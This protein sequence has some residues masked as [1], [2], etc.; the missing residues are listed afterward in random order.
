MSGLAIHLRILHYSDRLSLESEGGLTFIAQRFRFADGLYLAMV[1]RN[2]PSFFE[3]DRANGYFFDTLH[4]CLLCS[5]DP[6]SSQSLL[7]E[8]SV[9]MV[10]YGGDS[11]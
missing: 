8:Y 9:T 4:M 2:L 10:P 5:V 11:L 3:E 7:L 6:S 1:C